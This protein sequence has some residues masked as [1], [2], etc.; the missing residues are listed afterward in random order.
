MVGY[1]APARLQNLDQKAV[2][3][4]TETEKSINHNRHKHQ[5]REAAIMKN[6]EVT[7]KF[8]PRPEK[9]KFH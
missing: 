3:P 7:D 4:Q 2:K 5:E 6:K 8:Y 1:E 9:R